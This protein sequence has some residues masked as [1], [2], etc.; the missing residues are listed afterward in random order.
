MLPPF[1]YLDNSV[2]WEYNISP[3]SKEMSGLICKAIIKEVYKCPC[4]YE[5]D[6]L[7]EING[8][9]NEF[10]YQANEDF[11]DSFLEIGKEI[12]ADIFAVYGDVESA[13]NPEIF[14][15]ISGENVS[16]CGKIAIDIEDYD[17]KIEKSDIKIGDFVKYKGSLKV[18]FPETDYSF[19]NMEN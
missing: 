13:K 1:F 3:V 7:L 17:R 2:F 5:G 19:E 16:L 8:E 14:C 10:Y 9:K 6:I 4:G 15:E 12:K 11:A 18:C